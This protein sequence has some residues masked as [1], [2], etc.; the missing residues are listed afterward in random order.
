MPVVTKN[1]VDATDRCPFDGPAGLTVSSLEIDGDEFVL[2]EWSVATPSRELTLAER[3]VLDL[4]TSGASNAEIAR[5]RGTSAR[6]V[7]NQVASLLGKLN[8]RS[9]YDLIRRFG[10]TNVGRSS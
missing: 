4:V 10:A 5:Q 3:H 8:A 6:T 2:F 9:R 7:A 1:R